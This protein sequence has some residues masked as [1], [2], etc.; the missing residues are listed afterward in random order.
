MVIK[1]A[2]KNVRK[3]YKDYTVYFVTLAFSVALFYIF[4]SFQDQ[5]GIL[6]LTNQMGRTFEL[7]SEALNVISFIVVVIF[8]FLIVYANNFIIGR[9]KQEF[10]LYM[11]LGMSRFKMSLILMAE[12]FLIGL[13]ALAVGLFSGYILTQITSVLMGTILAVPIHYQFIFSTQ[14]ARRTIYCFSGIFVLIMFLN[15]RK[16]RKITLNELFNAHRTQEMLRNVSVWW[17]VFQ[18]I[19]AIAILIF[20]YLWVLKAGQLIFFMPIIVGIGIFATILLFKSMA[21]FVEYFVHINRSR[22]YRNLNLFVVRQVSNKIRSTYRVMAV[23]SITLL[24]GITILATGL[25]LNKRISNFAVETIPYDASFTFMYDDVGTV[26]NYYNDLNLNEYFRSG[27][28]IN[29][30][31]SESFDT[32]VFNIY[33]DIGEEK[34]VNEPLALMTL[35][36]YNKVRTIQNKPLLTLS[37]NQIYFQPDYNN[38]IT[39]RARLVDVLDYRKPLTLG[40]VDYFLQPYD[41][42]N[43]VIFSN[44]SNGYP[45]LVAHED[46]VNSIKATWPDVFIKTV[47]S[48]NALHST[49]GDIERILEHV[50]ER[51]TQDLTNYYDTDVLTR[52]NSGLTGMG[53]EIIIAAIGLYVGMVLLIV[54]LV[55]L[56]LQQL[57]EASD[58]QGRYETL[59]KIG[60]SH[61][62]INRALLKQTALYFFIPLGVALIHTVV[63][64]IAVERNL[65]LI[66]LG[67]TSNVLSVSTV[68]IVF[69][70]YLIYFVITYFNSKRIIKV[71]RK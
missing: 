65:N 9:R 48:G 20:D 70:F 29:L 21:E 3:S 44:Q 33:D 68:V 43:F 39:M 5:A 23:V 1:M 30:Y 59:R 10:G 62:M 17:T 66:N 61:A 18:L 49:E 69:M 31:R 8:A 11:L 26:K 4:G 58:N 32:E 16:L 25:N 57:S 24:F 6:E 45:I 37:K 64:L 67:Y 53:T 71:K 7:V 36:D 50:Q 13:A 27:F 22:Y 42:A 55:I 41:E 15:Q 52:Y 14:G 46:D 40:S 34:P 35:S 56:A 60:A 47:V 63:G 2:F 51:Q 12:T 54:S 19:G 28:Q 38:L